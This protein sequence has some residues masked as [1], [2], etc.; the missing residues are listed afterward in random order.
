MSKNIILLSNFAVASIAKMIGTE[1][2]AW[3]WLNGSGLEF[4]SC[5]WLCTNIAGAACYAILYKIKD[6]QLGYI[7]IPTPIN[8][9]Q[10][11][12]TSNDPTQQQQQPIVSTVVNIDGGDQTVNK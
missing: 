6:Q 3:L 10:K 12:T 7:P 5:I 2:S 1:V 4:L 8:N 9:T 11:Q